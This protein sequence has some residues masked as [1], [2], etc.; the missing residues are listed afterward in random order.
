MKT[1]TIFLITML[2]STFSFADTLNVNEK[3][4]RCR[5][6]FETPTT[7]ANAL[8]KVKYDL[9]NGIWKSSKFMY[10]T[11]ESLKTFS[12]KSNGDA[13]VVSEFVN[14]EV[15]YSEINWNLNQVGENIFLVLTDVEG[16]AENMYNI[17]QN[18]EG[19]VLTEVVFQ[20]HIVLEYSPESP[21]LDTK[22]SMDVIGKW[23][24]MKLGSTDN[25]SPVYFNF[26][27]RNKFSKIFV[28]SHAEKV[29]NGTWT[30]TKDG[31]YLVLHYD[32]E[33]NSNEVYKIDQLDFASM[34]LINNPA[35]ST[36]TYTGFEKFTFEKV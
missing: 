29:M 26:G 10:N 6:L 8:Y 17:K 32:D 2:L 28:E 19:I 33:C 34:T 11:K 23:K 16:V 22:I 27:Y 4:K 31:N 24:N 5:Q 20:K 15:T 21:I 7:A 13:T 30:I 25:N 18:C 35:N 14:G 3:D 36:I 12:F 9:E 1:T